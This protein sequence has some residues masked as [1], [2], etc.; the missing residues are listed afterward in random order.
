MIDM[1]DV[2]RTGKENTFFVPEDIRREMTRYMK[3]AGIPFKHIHFRKIREEMPE[4]KKETDEK[5]EKLGCVNHSC[6]GGIISDVDPE[7]MFQKS[8]LFFGDTID[9]DYK[10]SMDEFQ[11]ESHETYERYYSRLNGIPVKRS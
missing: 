6:I 2:R 1:S 9:P 10:K 8:L 4:I 7:D 3:K 5:Y 11:K